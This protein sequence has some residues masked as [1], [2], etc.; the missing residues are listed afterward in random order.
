MSSIS[1]IHLLFAFS[2]ENCIYLSRLIDS[3]KISKKVI[4]MSQTTLVIETNS[5]PVR[6]IKRT[7]ILGDDYLS[8]QSIPYAKPPIGSLRFRVTKFE[9]FPLSVTSI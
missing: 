8:F 3:L 7:T 4:E 9:F 2:V 5:G 1:V 6:G